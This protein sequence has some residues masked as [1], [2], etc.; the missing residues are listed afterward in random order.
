M[1]GL[2]V[3]FTAPVFLSFLAYIINPDWLAWS[4]LPLANE[5]RLGALVVALACIPAIGWVFTSIGGNISETVLTKAN[6]QLVMHGPYHWIRHPLYTFGLLT[7]CAVSLVA[8]NWFMLFATLIGALA[9]ITLVIPREEA[10]LIDK[11]G[12]AY[13]DYRKH[14]GALIPR[15][16]RRGDAARA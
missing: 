3:L 1:A 2:R 14:T 6:H 11:F 13:M 9:I 5:V 12:L 4:A 16:L 8:A 10:R 7:F 15:M